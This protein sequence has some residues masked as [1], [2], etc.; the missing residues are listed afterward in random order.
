[1]LE[2]LPLPEIAVSALQ[3]HQR[4]LQRLALASLAVLGLSASDG[5]RVNT[6]TFAA[7]RTVP[8]QT[9]PPAPL[10]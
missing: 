7:E 8:D 2:S 4:E 3:Q 9:D 10:P 1:M 6:D 5:W